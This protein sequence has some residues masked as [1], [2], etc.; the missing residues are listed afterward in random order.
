MFIA[1]DTAAKEPIYQQIH[2][3]I[4]AGIA[5]GEL[6]PGTQLPSVRSLGADLNVNLHTVNKAYA[7]LRDEG[8]IRMKGRSGAFIAEPS[9]DTK[10]DRVNKAQEDLERTLFQAALAF[11][12][13]GGTRGAFLEAA[14]SEAAKAFGAIP[15][16][17]DDAP[18]PVR[19]MKPT[20]DARGACEHPP[21]RTQLAAE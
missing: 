10:I 2:D 6:E 8:Y 18:A 4:V 9:G 16:D 11:R 15:L 5:L 17:T 1:I 3:Q 14:A 12:A 20:D 13:N 19:K 7:V 21:K